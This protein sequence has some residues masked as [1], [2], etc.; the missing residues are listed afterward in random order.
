MTMFCVTNEL[1]DEMRPCTRKGEHL[2]SCDG[3][4]YTYNPKRRRDESTGKVCR[5]CLPREANVGLLCYPCYERVQTAFTEWTPWFTETIAGI[6]R[7]VQRDNGGIRSASQGHIPLP[8]T[9]L[10]INEI[11]SY[12]KSFP[13]DTEQWV[14]SY[15]GA[16]DA[17]HFSK[18]VPAARRTHQVEEKAYRIARTRCP[19][20]KQQSLIWNPPAKQG[21]DVTVTCQNEACKH[22]ISQDGYEVLK[23]VKVAQIDAGERVEVA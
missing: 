15:F 6:D 19:E 3:F 10:A 14:S 7:L 12:L 11:E 8:G 18:A 1:A 23:L 21:A 4:E 20:C 2:I 9:M 22:Q 5:G 13:G 16:V 17:I